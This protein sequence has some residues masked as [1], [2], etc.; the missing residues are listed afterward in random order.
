MSTHRD[1]A[2][3]LLEQGRYGAAET[4]LRA[5]LAQEPTVPYLH[6]LL[7]LAIVFQWKK[8]RYPEALAE[9]RQGIA[10]APDDADAHDAAGRVLEE[11]EDYAGAEAAAREAIRLVPDGVRHR[12]LLA[13]VLL[14]QKRWR[15]ALTAAEEG[16][17][18]N[19]EDVTCA[20]VR[21]TALVK[22]GQ[23]AE[24]GNTLESALRVNPDNAHTHANMGWVL[25]EKSQYEKALEH[26]GE[27][28]RL[29]PT[30]EWA[31]QGVVEAL[32]ARHVVYAVMLRFFLWMGRL[33][34]RMQWM[35]IIG[36][37]VAYR[38]V[39]GIAKASPA[40]APFLWPL[41]I[42]YIV[43]VYLTWTASPLFNLLLRL[44]RYGRLAL[45]EEQVRASNWVGAFM[46]MAVIAIPI[47]IL[48]WPGLTLFVGVWA[49]IMVIPIA[50]TFGAA[51]GKHRAILGI[52][53]ALLGAMGLAIIVLVGVSNPSA[54]ILT[55]FF[56]IGVFVFG[57]VANYLALR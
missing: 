13:S 3:L 34:N 37:Y 48:T 25:I 54:A 53:T 45:S 29:D 30:S 49:L 9:A 8:H 17:T 41:V 20:N 10:G 38:I 50:G 44:N 15:E 52:Y 36:A 6:S 7:A 35:V 26:F 32:K 21:A 56:F 5:A 16:L 55:P 46:L 31:R 47:G 11:M 19:S 1:Y 12:A 42:L 33:S 14:M 23:R 18:L 39:V 24:A 4:E 22:L 27:S 40:A 28:L 57:W 43:F 2:M 51:A